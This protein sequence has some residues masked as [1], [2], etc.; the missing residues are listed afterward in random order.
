MSDLFEAVLSK[1]EWFHE[2]H[3]MEICYSLSPSNWPWLLA[4]CQDVAVGGR[5]ADL[6]FY[7]SFFPLKRLVRYKLPE[8]CMAVALLSKHSLSAVEIRLT[9]VPALIPES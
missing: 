1:R 3:L 9:L 4:L 6:L 5:H 2:R 8:Q 7:T